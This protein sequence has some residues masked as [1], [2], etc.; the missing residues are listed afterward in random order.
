[1]SH[2]LIIVGLYRPSIIN[3][4]RAIL[5]EEAGKEA[6]KEAKTVEKAEVRRVDR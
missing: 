3:G 2:P 5:F 6:G 4:G 1:M